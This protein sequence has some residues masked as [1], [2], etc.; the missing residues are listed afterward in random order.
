MLR[1]GFNL[2]IWESKPGSDEF[3]VDLPRK[4]EKSQEYTE[5]SSSCKEKQKK[6]EECGSKKKKL[7]VQIVNTVSD[8]NNQD[9]LI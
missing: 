8:S 6:G 5:K 7:N 9:T 1:K 2:R 3:S 4:A